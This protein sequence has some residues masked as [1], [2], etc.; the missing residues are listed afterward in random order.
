MDGK[1]SAKA[2]PRKR[3]R[4]LLTLFEHDISPRFD[5]T[6]EVLIIDLDREGT[7]VS[8]RT[9]VLPHASAEELSHLILMEGVKV[10]ICGGIEEE[11]YQYLTWK[12]IEVM[13]SIMGSWSRALSLFRKGQL[14][15]GAFLFDRPGGNKHAA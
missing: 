14:E 6:T 2:L 1:A 11:F 10:V 9:V 3:Q 8:E 12:K 4:V 13:D 15:P 7:V 5:L